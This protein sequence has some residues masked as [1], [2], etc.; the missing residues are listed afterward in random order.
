MKTK[1][2]VLAIMLAFG[3]A[4]SGCG[5]NT[6]SSNAEQ[7]TTSDDSSKKSEGVMTYQEYLDAD[8]DSEIVIETYVQDKQEWWE[9]KASLYTQDQDGAYFIYNA[10]CTKD[11]YDKLDQGTKIKVTGYKTEWSGEIEVAEGATIEIL[12][13]NYI[14]PATN[15]TDILNDKKALL[16]HQNQFVEFTDMTIEPIGDDEAVYLY[17]Y[18]G[19]GAEGDDLY[20]NASYKGET[21]NFVVESYLTGVDSE[22][23]KTVK[24][25]K[26]GDKVDMEGYL[27]W[28]EGPNPHIISVTVK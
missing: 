9:D 19:S 14:A 10:D 1:D 13:G 4:L 27:Y 3:M 20:F 2:A 5:N 22:V 21:Y 6:N 24:D 7:S 23:Y 15:I 16:E 12:D 17:N 28:Y 18:D 25:L 26:I 8:N 11:M